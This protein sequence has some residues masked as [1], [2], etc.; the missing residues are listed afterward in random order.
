LNN[1][2]K[3]SQNK[4]VS[5]IIL[6]A[7]TGSRMRLGKNKLLHEIDQPLLCYSVETF[8]KHELVDNIIIV[9]SKEDTDAIK[10]ITKDYAKVKSVVN[11]GLKRQD[12]SY[13][14][15]MQAD[16]DIILVHDG[17]RAFVDSET[18]TQ[19]VNGAIDSGACIA[20][21]PSKDTIKTV[22]D[23]YVIQ[24]L[25]RDSTWMIQTPQAFKSEVIKNAHQKAKEDGFLGTDEAMLVE[26][27]GAKVKIV[28]GNY[29][30][31]KI[32][33]P[34]DLINAKEV[35]KCSR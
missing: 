17:A 19:T 12:S 18:I 22:K 6:A 8:D 9:S 1:T 23:G 32:T 5:A 14:G 3:M 35:V 30:N 4:P 15:V 27:I 31:F 34:E 28:M 26:R 24:T 29:N 33:T 2:L 25:K 13:N 10:E 7:G 16:S 21:V 20:A 11:G